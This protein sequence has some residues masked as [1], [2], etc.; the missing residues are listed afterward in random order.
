[1]KNV[2]SL[3]LLPILALASLFIKISGSISLRPVLTGPDMAYLS[4][5]VA[6]RCHARDSSPP[7]T[8]TLMLDGFPIAKTTDDQGEEPLSFFLKV[9]AAS[10]G[11]YHCEAT[12]GENT[13][14]SNTIK[15]SIVTPP[16][17]TR[18]T[19]EPSPPIVYE[20]KR[21]VLYCNTTRGS[22][23]SYA[24]FFNR[25][26]V[27]SSIPPGFHLTRNKLLV[28]KVTPEHAGLY[29]CMAL[30]TVQDIRRF[31]SSGEVKVTV[32]VLISKPKISF[33]ISKEGNIYHG[34][35]TCWS[36][37]GSHPA[38]FSFSI[39]GKEVASVT[40]TESISAWFPVTLVPGLDMGVAQ[41]QVK[42]EMQELMSEPLSLEVVPVGGSVKV[43]VD[44]L[45]R[46]DSSLAAARLSCQ[47]SRGTF[48]YVSWFF[49]DSV[50]PPEAPMDSLIQPVL[51][52][53]ALTNKRR[54]LTLIKL[55]PEESGYYRCR[56]RNSYDD[57]GS[58]VESVAVMVQ[59]KGV[60][61]TTIEIISISFCC[62]LALVMAVFVGC[63][64]RIFAQNQGRALIARANCKEPAPSASTSLTAGKQS[65]AATADYNVHSQ[66]QIT[67]TAV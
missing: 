39:D 56:A 33:S 48:P 24:W 1:M 52:H 14:V 29:S 54:T 22:H 53:Y 38:N 7:V 63:V 28:E 26:E 12:T 15:L 4:S 65:G 3:N 25:K 57:S 51:P 17:N 8:Y 36:T 50:L 34:N 42:T 27:T 35:V 9:T 32:K 67:E 30:S 31:S 13:A 62:F 19:S 49:N 43:E 44:Y 45:Y 23:L 60:Y 16:S 37:R 41:C 21:I 59:V 18:V 6:F 5:R 11:S 47:I 46:V 61:I 20:G 64:Y 55:G 66:F 58:W 40:A 10:A 2:Q